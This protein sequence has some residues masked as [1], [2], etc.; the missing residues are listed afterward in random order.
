M[1]TETD[2]AGLDA[3]RRRSKEKD[4]Q[5]RYNDLK[6]RVQDRKRWRY[7]SCEPANR[8]TT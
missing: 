8:Q 6:T 7:W 5:N 2:D 4:E 1:T 3:C